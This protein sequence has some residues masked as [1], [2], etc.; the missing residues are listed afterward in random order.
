MQELLEWFLAETENGLSDARMLVSRLD[1]ERKRITLMLANNRNTY[2]AN[3]L[4][5]AFAVSSCT[6]IANPPV[7]ICL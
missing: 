6:L 4:T 3:L 2:V 1:G 5:S 7:S